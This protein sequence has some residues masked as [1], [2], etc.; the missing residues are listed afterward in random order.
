MISEAAGEARNATAPATSDGVPMRCSAAMRSTV[1]AR[2]A[3]SLSAG[4]VPSVSTKVGATALTRMPSPP[5]STARH[6]VRWITAAL[7]VQ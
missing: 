1:S 2:N 7:A 3:G 6:F 4:S 5:H